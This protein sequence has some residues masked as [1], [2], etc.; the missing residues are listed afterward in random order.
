MFEAHIDCATVM[1]YNFE[2]IAKSKS[3][4][5]EAIKH[6]KKKIYGVQFHPESSGKQ[7]Y[8]ILD[9]FMKICKIRV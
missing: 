6:K 4:K 1:P 7:G 5:I 9:N 3:C 2:I 8:Q